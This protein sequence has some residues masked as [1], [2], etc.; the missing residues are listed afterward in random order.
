MYEC[1]RR[2]GKNAWDALEKERMCET[3][4]RRKECVR[5]EGKNAWDEKEGMRE[6]RRKECVRRECVRMRETRRKECVRRAWQTQSLP[7][8]CFPSRLP[9]EWGGRREKRV[10]ERRKECE[11]RAWH[12]QSVTLCVSCALSHSRDAHD[13]HKVCDSESMFLSRSPGG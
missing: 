13:T 3:R 2:Q 8:P 1:V 6:T 10:C 12:T 4:L 7:N 9:R 11:R 5:R